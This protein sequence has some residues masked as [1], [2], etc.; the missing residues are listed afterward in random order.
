MPDDWDVSYN[1]FGTKL[2]TT[3]ER[4]TYIAQE[5][6]SSYGENPALIWYDGWKEHRIILEWEEI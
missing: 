2:I 5:I 4:E 1:K 3:P 6:I